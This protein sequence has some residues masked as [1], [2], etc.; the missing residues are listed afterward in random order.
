MADTYNGFGLLTEEQQS[1]SGSVTTATPAVY[2]GYSTD[3]AT[4]TRLISM[5]YPN[6][7]VLTYGYNTGADNAVGR[8]SYLAD[9]DST[10]LADYSYLGLEQID[11][12]SNPEPGVTLDLGHKNGSGQLDRVDQFN[13]ATDMIFA[14]TGGNIDQIMQGYDVSGNELWQAQPTAAS[15]GV[16]LDKLN[17]YN[18]LNELTGSAQGTLNSQHTAITANQNQTEAWTLDGMGNWSNYTQTVGGTDH[19]RSGPGHERPERNHGLQQHL[20][21]GR[22]GLRCRRQHDHDAPARQRN[23]RLDLRVRCL[24]PPGRGGKRFP[25]DRAGNLFL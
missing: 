8:V 6:G 1:V 13:R 15:N 2:Y 9:S 10:Q 5:T 14:E 24:E 25:A 22:A 12:V 19:G 17:G 7:R 20:N 11:D 21:L 23:D 4:P 16:Y 18:A 3:S